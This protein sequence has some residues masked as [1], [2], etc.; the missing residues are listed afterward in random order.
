VYWDSVS[1]NGTN[2][3]Y[4]VVLLCTHTFASTQQAPFL[5]SYSQYCNQ[6][7]AS[8]ATLMQCMANNSKFKSFLKV[9]IRL[10]R[11]QI[12]KI[13]YFLFIPGHRKRTRILTVALWTSKVFSSC[14]F[15]EFLAMFYCWRTFWNIQ[16]QHILI[17]F[18]FP[19][20][21]PWYANNERAISSIEQD[22]HY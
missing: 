18:R 21:F 14:P 2:L 8:N 12:W 19:T 11:C 13:T 22:S 7:E 15:S 6:F 9:R 1:A 16:I 4:L 20:L 5:K 17:T 3:V 10:K